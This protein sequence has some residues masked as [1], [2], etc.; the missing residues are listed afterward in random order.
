MSSIV[1]SSRFLGGTELSPFYLCIAAVSSEGEK[2]YSEGSCVS[3]GT[4]EG[5]LPFSVYVQSIFEVVS[6]SWGLG[7]TSV[8]IRLKTKPSARA[9]GGGG[10]V[11]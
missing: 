5:H 7:P 3:D 9:Y 11:L 1:S 4:R 10:G 6:L 2:S 8:C